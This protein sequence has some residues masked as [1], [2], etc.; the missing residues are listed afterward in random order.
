MYVNTA[1]YSE[2]S[3]IGLVVLDILPALHKNSA[4]YGFSKFKFEVQFRSWVLFEV[5]F[6]S[7]LS[8]SKLGRSKLGR[9]KLG[10]SKFSRS[11][12]SR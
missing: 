12:F 7:K 8:R 4:I 1:L 5:E 11:K 10:R 2:S 3:N 9:T 6:F